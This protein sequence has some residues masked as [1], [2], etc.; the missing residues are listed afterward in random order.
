MSKIDVAVGINCATSPELDTPLECGL[1]VQTF[2]GGVKCL[3]YSQGCAGL[4]G[5]CTVPDGLRTR[6]EALTSSLTEGPGEVVLHGTVL[7]LS[8]S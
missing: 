6:E 5:P 2:R 3:Q 7:A 1:Y 4:L 8:S